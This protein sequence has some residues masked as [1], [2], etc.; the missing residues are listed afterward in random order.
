MLKTTLS[1]AALSLALLFSNSVLAQGMDYLGPH[2]N[3]S[4]DHVDPNQGI[5][6]YN[7][8]CSAAFDGSQ[9]CESIDVLR[10]GSTGTTGD[11]D[12]IQWVKPTLV[13]SYLNGQG[14]TVFVDASGTISDDLGGLSCSG[15]SSANLSL[16][17][18]NVNVNGRFSLA[19]CQVPLPIACCRAKR[20]Q[21]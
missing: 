9:M 12:N 5:I 14:D 17:G 11:P 7:E 10:S 19:S 6:V 20:K 4:N 2:S 15:W 21:K 16:T 8:L 13:A 18:L 1:L 3:D